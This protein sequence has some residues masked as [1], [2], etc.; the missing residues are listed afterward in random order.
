MNSLQDEKLR[1]QSE[2][3]QLNR[4]LEA[5]AAALADVTKVYL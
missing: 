4:A 5:S 3:V 1:L 2:L